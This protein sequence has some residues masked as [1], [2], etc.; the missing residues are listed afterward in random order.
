VITAAKK[1]GASGFGVD[2]DGALVSEAK[3]EAQ[4]QG[5]SGRVDFYARN[6]FITDI[7][8]AT[9]LTSYLFPQVNMEL[10]P[11][12]FAELKPGTRVV[13]HEFDFGNWK[14]DA[15]RR[16]AVPNKRYGPP[17]S[18]VYLW[19]VPANVAGTWRWRVPAGAEAVDCEMKLDQTFQSLR[20]TARAA[21]RPARI[22][23]AAISGEN[24]ALALVLE[25][26]GRQVRQELKGRVE[27]DAI[28]GRVRT[29]GQGDGA[30]TEWVATRTL[31]GKINTDA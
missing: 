14:P 21:G 18:D 11:R 20:G 4:R 5:V 10:R 28:R 3:R 22:E 17:H 1:Y 16:I 27:G 24:V 29:S 8:K 9:V 26:D 23:S 25:I 31:R 15:H 30:D 13:A 19:I 7:G 12:L 2:L 6:L